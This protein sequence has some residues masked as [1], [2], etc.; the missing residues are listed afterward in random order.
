MFGFRV[1]GDARTAG[2][3]F[4]PLAVGVAEESG[5][6]AGLLGK[7]RLVYH[8]GLSVRGNRRVNKRAV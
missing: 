7:S 8:R 5:V 3:M 4:A 1:A 2:G 6:K